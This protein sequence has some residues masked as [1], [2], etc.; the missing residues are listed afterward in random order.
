MRLIRSKLRKLMTLVGKG[1]FALIAQ[2]LRI[3]LWSDEHVVV[4]RR[5]LTQ[6][7]EHPKSPVA[8]FIRPYEP[9][10]ANALF[11]PGSPLD[12]A[13]RVKHE[14]WME[15]GMKACY[16]AVL[17]DGRP[18]FIQWLCAP[19]D[20]KPLRDSF[21]GKLLAIEPGTVLLEHAYTPPRFRRLAVAPAAMA[22]IAEEGLRLGAR[23]ALVHVGEDN[24]SMIK[25][26][27]WAGFTPW[28]LKHNRRRLFR[29]S[30]SYS[31]LPAEPEPHLVA[32]GGTRPPMTP[33]VR[34]RG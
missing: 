22:R 20:N 21:H 12:Q 30:V 10:D 26:A 3:H 29:R 24:A 25:A 19:S 11:D 17:E 16:V 15:R 6:A 2:R 7:I 8:F 34:A 4:L 1:E 23:R 13:E 27:Q 14:N 31:E 5:D 33:R 28:R 9:G 18:V 32:A